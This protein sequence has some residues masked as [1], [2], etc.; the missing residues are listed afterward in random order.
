MYSLILIS[1]WSLHQCRLLGHW[2]PVYDGCDP[3]NH[4]GHLLLVPA[5]PHLLHR[6][7]VDLVVAVNI[8]RGVAVK[9]A[10]G[11]PAVRCR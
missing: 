4:G 3:L 1:H 8:E 10:R 11:Q 6:V 9:I 2:L 7:P 5:S